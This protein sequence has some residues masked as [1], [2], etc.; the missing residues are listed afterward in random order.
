MSKMTKTLGQLEAEYLKRK[1][2]I[3]EDPGLSWEK[4]ELSIRQLGDEYYRQ[5][6]ELEGEAA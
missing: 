1:A 6:R 5:R 2:E 4:K 3:R